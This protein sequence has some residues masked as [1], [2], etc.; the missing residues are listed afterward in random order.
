[1]LREVVHHYRFER[2]IG[3][4]SCMAHQAAATLLQSAYPTVVDP[5][6]Y[7]GVLIE[8]TEKEHRLWFW[9]CCRH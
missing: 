9:H 3:T 5:M 2:S 4:N 6:N 1:M 7:S 8:W